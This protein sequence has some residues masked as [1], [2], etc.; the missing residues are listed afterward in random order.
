MSETPSLF[1][2]LPEFPPPDVE[3]PLMVWEYVESLRRITIRYQKA[4]VRCVLASGA[5]TSGGIPKYPPLDE[6]V[7]R[8]VEQLRKDYDEAINGG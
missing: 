2:A 3:A 4:L 5:D 7:V 1:D 8:E 6:W